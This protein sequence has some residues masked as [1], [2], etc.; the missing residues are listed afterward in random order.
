[1]PDPFADDVIALL[2]N[3]RRF[4]ISLSRARDTADDLVQMTVERAFASRASFDPAT[5]LD[6][7]L[8]RILRNAW[9][10]MVRRTK[11]RGTEIDIADAPDAMIVDG[12]KTV[13]TSLMLKSAGV[14]IGNLP[15]DQREVILLIC[16]EELSYKEAAETLGIPIGTVMSRLSR[17][18]IAISQALGINPPM[19]RS[20]GRAGD[21]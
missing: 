9:Y 15:A 11:T 10:D 2:P 18:R 21:T 4:A 5:R 19:A 3:L 12:E 13:E 20:P 16:V 7:W 14:A 17:A 6:A 1:M 8:F